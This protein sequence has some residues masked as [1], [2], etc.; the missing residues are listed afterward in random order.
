MEITYSLEKDDIVACRWATFSRS[1]VARRFLIFN[2]LLIVLSAAYS[3]SRNQMDLSQR[4]SVFL[5]E[6]LLNFLIVLVTSY[7]AVSFLM[8][9]IPKGRNNGLLGEHTVII[10]EEAFEER[11]RVNIT[12]H[13]WFGLHRIEEDNEYIRVYISPDNYHIIPKRAFDSFE[14]AGLFLNQVRG[15]FQS[16]AS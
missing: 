15:F 10:S 9:A 4:L 6:F 13:F 5:Y 8:R 1:T 12:K 14:T 7:V 11:T 3:A 2:F 16:N